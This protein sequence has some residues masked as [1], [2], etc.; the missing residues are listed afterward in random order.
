MK[1]AVVSQSPKTI[2]DLNFLDQQ[3]DLSFFDTVAAVGA[4]DLTIYDADIGKQAIAQHKPPLWMV[5]NQTDIF[6]ALKFFQSGAAAILGRSYN[7]KTL[8]DCINTVHAGGIYIEQD[9][10]QILAM[11]QIRKLLAPFSSLSSR[12]FDVFCLLAEGY[13]I[14]FIA[15]D[16]G[17]SCK[18]VFN[19]QTQ[20]KTKLSLQNQ[21]QMEKFAK[22]NGLI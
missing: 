1:I 11:R 16:L 20:I 5:I 14:P 8:C 2:K 13:S 3:Y 12:E 9:M 4:C 18:T 15:E 21:Q 10:L 6:Q 7:R 17:I 19:C 22:N